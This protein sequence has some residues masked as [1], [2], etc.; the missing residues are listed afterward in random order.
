MLTKFPAVLKKVGFQDFFWLDGAGT[1][2]IDILVGMGET[3]GKGVG[4]RWGKGLQ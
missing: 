2:L 1:A 4:K 3:E